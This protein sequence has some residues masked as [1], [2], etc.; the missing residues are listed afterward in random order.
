MFHQRWKALGG[1]GILSGV[2]APWRLLPFMRPKYL[3]GIRANFAGL[4]ACRER[5]LLDCYS[6][7]QDRWALL[8]FKTAFNH[9]GQIGMKQ[10]DSRIEQILIKM[11]ELLTASRLLKERHDELTEEYLNLKR[12]LRER[13][14]GKR[15]AV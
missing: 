15:T 13:T 8:Q 14:A 1:T 11:Q 4:R 2:G 9:S 7:L 12:E 3:D 10:D 5:A 6:S